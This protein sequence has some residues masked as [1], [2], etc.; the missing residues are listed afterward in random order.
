MVVLFSLCLLV[1]I[2]AAG[3][4]LDGGMASATRRQ[5]QNAADTAALAAAKA[6]AAGQDG[7]AAAQS[8]SATNGFPASAADCSGNSITGVTVN[9]PPTSGTYSGVSGYVE[10]VTKRA[11]RTGFAGIVGQNCW[12]V[13]AR[14][15]ASV[16]NAGV[17]TCNFCA[18]NNSNK[19]H[20]LVLQNSAE[21]RVDGDI[22]VNSTNGGTTP[23]V[24]TLNKWNVC[25]DGFDIFGTGGSI[26][27]KTIS[28]VGGWE[29]HDQNIATADGLAQTNGANCPEH[30]NPP[31]QAQTA[32]VCIH[33]PVLAD[34][35]NDP[36]RPGNIVHPPTAGS[37]PI[38]GQNGCP[39]T[40]TS[41]SGTASSP[42]LLTISSGTPTICPGTY[43]GGIKIQS[44]ASVTMQAGVYNIVGGGFQV[45]GSS[46]VDGS[47]G[48][49]IYNSSGT[50]E[51]VST[52]A[53]SDHVPAP[54][55]G[56]KTPSLNNGLASSGNNSSPGATVTYTMTID[57]GNG[58][59]APT[60]TVDFYDGD[61]VVCAAV[62]LVSAGGTKMSASCAQTYAVW[63]THA[64]SAVYDGDAIYDGIGDTFSQ[65]VKTPAGTGIQ[66]VTISTTGTVKLYGPK[67]GTYE[68][69]TIFQDR[70]SNLTLTLSPGSSGVTCP[71]GFMTATLNGAAAWKDGCGAIGGLQGTIYASSAA[72]LITASGLSPLQVISDTIQVTSGANARFAY[73][74]SLFANGHIR[75]VE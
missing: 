19:N 42:V 43:Y 37:R 61:T 20:T 69:L 44:S 5:A 51:A 34:P 68:G 30:P 65:T 26:S 39:T 10:V 72:V 29:T 63:G 21:L 17:A 70:S 64:M 50:G 58:T 49:M 41:G 57:R 56:H 9:N 3:L 53:G 25:G 14:A 32:N 23:G 71:G 67:T 36:T 28:V 27:A 55:A 18:L 13:S 48:V 75:L 31:S 11:M 62:T 16:N 40:A 12:M 60:G 22:Y 6:I 4:L 46:S 2:A 38:A 45:I 74:A 7:T 24:C 54:I 15:V 33:M 8:I 47:A 59:V 73:N 1:I 66:A 35:L 52:T